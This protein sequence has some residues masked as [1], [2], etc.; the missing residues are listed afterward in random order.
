MIWDDQLGP[1]VAKNAAFQK[2]ITLFRAWEIY[3]PAPH[4][5][6]RQFFP[7]VLIRGGSKYTQKLSFIITEHLK[8][9]S[10]QKI[11]YKAWEAAKVRKVV[12]F[13]PQDWL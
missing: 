10:G 13:L 3:A 2:M 8:L 1:S 4:T 7:D 5:T 6:Y 11:S 9:V 12:D